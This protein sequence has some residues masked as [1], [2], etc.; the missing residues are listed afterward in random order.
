MAAFQCVGTGWIPRRHLLYLAVQ[1]YVPKDQGKDGSKQFPRVLYH[2]K[3]HEKW[4]IRRD[5]K[6]EREIILGTGRHSLFHRGNDEQ[7]DNNQFF[8]SS[9]IA[10]LWV[11]SCL[12]TGCR[13]SCL[14]TRSH[15]P[16]V[17]CILETAE[18]EWLKYQSNFQSTANKFLPGGRC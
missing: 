11:Q 10:M 9:C 1:L 16:C 3:A 2:R 12:F 4:N 13:R 6:E 7:D 5:L 14:M 17:P 8:S 15:S 18:E